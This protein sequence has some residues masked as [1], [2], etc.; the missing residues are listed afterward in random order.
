MYIGYISNAKLF[1]VYPEKCLG[2]EFSCEN[3]DYSRYYGLEQ[4]SEE[5]V[6]LEPVQNCGSKEFCH[7]H[8]VYDKYYIVADEQAGYE[9]VAV[10]V[11]LVYDA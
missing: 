7:E 4:Q 1:S 6:A 3:Y 5:L 8:T 9:I 11:E 10:V 2:Y